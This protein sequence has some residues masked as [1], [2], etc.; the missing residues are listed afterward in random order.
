MAFE[1]TGTGAGRGSLINNERVYYTPLP[2]K[3]TDASNYVPTFNFANGTNPGE[4]AGGFLPEILEKEVQRFGDRRLSGFLMKVGGDIPF[5]SSEIRW[6]EQGR[7]HS[8]YINVTLAATA[9]GDAGKTFTVRT[10]GGTRAS[11]AINHNLRVGQTFIFQDGAG[12]TEKGV[13][14]STTATTFVGESYENAAWGVARVD[15]TTAGNSIGSL[16]VYGSD[17]QK[18]SFGLEGSLEPEVDIYSS[19]P[20]IIKGNYKING[21][22]T[23]QIGWIEGTTEDG[24]TGYLWYLKAKSEEMI[25][26]QDDME[27]SLIEGIPAEATSGAATA[28]A[29][30]GPSGASTGRVTSAGFGG[31][32]GFFYQIQQRG[33]IFEDIFGGAT[34]SATQGD[35]DVEDIILHLDKQGAI[36]DNLYFL[37]RQTSLNMDKWLATKNSYGSGGTSYGVFNNSEDM[38]L[39][40]GFKGYYWGGYDFYKTDWKYL[41][42][43]Q[44][45]GTVGDIDGVIVPAG[46]MTNYDMNLGSNATRPFVYM[47]YRTS[48]ADNRKFKYWITGSVGGAYTTDEDAMRVNLLSER[49]LVV[50]A[51]NNFILLQ[52][53]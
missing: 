9:A 6:T 13:V 16:F 32:E 49:A 3:F 5:T 38:A 17:F 39:H 23:A 21:S 31:N 4:I 34:F 11:T 25:R 44:G 19:T 41:N 26:F 29:V 40:L 27:L 24:T 22:D 45:R 53:G 36:K 14:K 8:T 30:S 12:A 48:E 10:N 28:G 18:G 2:Q 42:D 47:A 37:N 33:N 46:S 15:A 52:Q 1:S 20:V 50:Q 51:A 7:L 35:T 43:V